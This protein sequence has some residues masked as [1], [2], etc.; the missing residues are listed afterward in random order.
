MQMVSNEQIIW[1]FLSTRGFPDVAVAGIMGN[2]YAESA[3]KSN[4]LQGTY[5][6]S[7]GMTD[8]AYTTA[9]DDGTYKNFIHDSAGYGLAQWTYWS[10]KNAL[11]NFCQTCKCSIGDIYMQLNFFFLELKGSY[12]PVY[13][14]LMNATS[15]RE[16][17]DIVLLQYEKPK[18]QSEAVQLKRAEKGDSYYKKYAKEDTSGTEKASLEEVAQEVISGKWGNNPERKQK[19]TVA[20]YNYNE[21]QALVNK[22]VKEGK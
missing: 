15:V 6:K 17:S 10:R 3:L 11:Y 4:N 2:F 5:E 1:N 19:L 16:A 7:L 20:G 12:K 21:V 22:L 18:N 13:N 8:T 14:G 9:V